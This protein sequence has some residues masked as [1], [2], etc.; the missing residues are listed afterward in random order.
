VSDIVIP[1]QIKSY[2]ENKYVV[3]STGFKPMTETINGRLAMVGFLTEIGCVA[4]ASERL[5]A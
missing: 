4:G 2:V 1:P 3:D 5:L